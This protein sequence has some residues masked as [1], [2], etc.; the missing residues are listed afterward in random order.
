MQPRRDGAAD[1]RADGVVQHAL[2]QLRC[3]LRKAVAQHVGGQRV[4][5][6]RLRD[7]QLLDGGRCQLDALIEDRR[8]AVAHDF[9][10]HVRELRRR[11]GYNNALKV[12]AQLVAGESFV[13]IRM[14]CLWRNVAQERLDGRAEPARGVVEE[15][16]HARRVAKLL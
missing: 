3:P 6:R 12:R 13:D 11:C 8:E 4:R 16:F 9:A 1:C 10:Q 14:D 2:G 7:A 15:L 5:L